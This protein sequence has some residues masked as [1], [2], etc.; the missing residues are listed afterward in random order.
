MENLFLISL[1]EQLLIFKKKIA[2]HYLSSYLKK[3]LQESNGGNKER[4]PFPKT[5]GSGVTNQWRASRTQT[6]S[7]A[8]TL[9][10]PS[11]D[12]HYPFGIFPHIY[13]RNV[14][15][16][17]SLDVIATRLFS[18]MPT[19]THRIKKKAMKTKFPHQIIGLP[20]RYISI[21]PAEKNW[22]CKNWGIIK[23]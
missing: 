23:H 14:S 16:L 12:I 17:I 11:D 8:A 21:E 2:I 4:D 22:P 7:Y 13:I 20:K 15:L 1:Q 6:K 10:A 19:E 3:V 5:E 18:R 9:F